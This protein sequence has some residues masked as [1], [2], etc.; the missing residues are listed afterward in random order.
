MNEI[1]GIE[2]FK[3]GTWNGQP[4][5]EDD[6]DQMVKAF[7]SLGYRPTLKLG[8][9]KG[10]KESP[11][12]GY[13]KNLYRQGKT[14]LADFMDVPNKVLDAIKNRA[15]DAV[16]A[17]IYQNLSRNGETYPKALK[18]VALLGD[19]IPAVD[20]KPL[21]EVVLDQVEFETVNIDVIEFASSLPLA[22]RSRPWDAGAAIARVRTFTGATDVP[23]SRFARAF[24]WHDPQNADNF[25]AYKLPIADVINGRLMAVPRAI[26]AA[27][28]LQ[29][30]RGGVNI[31]DSAKATARSTLNGYYSKLDAT[32]PWRNS[33]EQSNYSALGDFLKAQRDKKG[34]SNADLAKAAGI[35]ESTVGQILGGDISAPPDNRLRGF[36]RIL[37]VSFD[38]LRALI[39]ANRRN[40]MEQIDELNEKIASLE[41]E[42][43]QAKESNIFKQK[44]DEL[45]EQLKAAQDEI[46]SLHEQNRQ[47]VVKDKS[48]QIKVPALR[49]C[50]ARV[51]EIATQSELKFEEGKVD[52]VG[53]V[54]ALVEEINKLSEKYFQESTEGKT[55]RKESF[56][57]P[58]DELDAEI[59]KYMEG[60][61]DARYSDA[62]QAVL[63]ENPE[64]ADRYNQVD[65]GHVLN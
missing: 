38:R 8:H 56:D 28:A 11:A 13:V 17:E 46:V 41:A 3:A 36:A 25:A 45:S 61:K 18:A 6:L 33:M 12:L 39:P 22:D 47:A 54:D 16:S 42:L 24:L 53:A 20:L 51:Y 35:D 63:V 2:I 27:A 21:H 44:T 59:K 65:T 62:M 30:A 14:L 5:S 26:F 48:G 60:H 9:Q 58:S 32:P 37:G 40:S 19:S 55:E 34:L 29:G 64:L 31:P 43:K 49:D 10:D 50:F 57:T 1:N 4:F 7:G 52:S 15:Y 23:N